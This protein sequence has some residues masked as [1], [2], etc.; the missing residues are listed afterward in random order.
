MS[1][2]NSCNTSV[3]IIN[4]RKYC[5][6]KD[7]I[8]IINTQ[9]TVVNNIITNPVSLDGFDSRIEFAGCTGDVFSQENHI[10]AL[11]GGT[12]DPKNLV[13]QTVGSN[14]TFGSFLR[15]DTLTVLKGDVRGSGANDLSVSRELC[16][17]VA[18]GDFSSILSGRNNTASGNLS[19]VVGGSNNISSGINSTIVS[20][21]ENINDGPGSVLIS[22]ISN[23][24]S[25]IGN[26]YNVIGC[27]I[28]NTA[29][30]EYN[31]IISGTNNI[32]Q[33]SE[34]SYNVISSGSRNLIQDS[35]F[36]WI[37]TGSTNNILSGIYNVIN[38]GSGNSNLGIE[39]NCINSGSNNKILNGFYNTIACGS[40]CLI[41]DNTKF[42]GIFTG[43]NNRIRLD[44]SYCCIMGGQNNDISGGIA[45]SI[46]SGLNNNIMI[47]NQGFNFIGSGI[48]NKVAGGFN[49]IVSGSNNLIDTS[50]SIYNAIVSGNNNK[51]IGGISNSFIGAG[52]NNRIENVN[53]SA[54]IAGASGYISGS[55]STIVG[56]SNNLISTPN[57]FAC[58]LGLRLT[59][60]NFPSTA[61]GQYNLE[62]VTGATGGSL[63]SE[64]IFMVGNGND[65]NNRANAFS[66]TVDGVCLAPLGFFTGGADF[67][68]YFESYSNY[69][70]KKI[71]CCKSAVMIDER[72]I[73]KSID[74]TTKEFIDS[75]NGFTV[76]D[77][78]KIM[79]ASDAPETIEPFGVIVF[80]SGFV[81][82]S[83]DEEW[84]GKYLKDSLNNFVYEDNIIE[85]EEEDCVYTTKEIVEILKERRQDKN[86]NIYYV[87]TPVKRTLQI[88]NPILEKFPLYNENGEWIEYFDKPK[89]VKKS[90]VI[91]N[92]KLSPNYDPSLVYIARSDRPEWNLVALLGQ[93]MI[94]DGQRVKPTWLKMN[95]INDSIHKYF[96]K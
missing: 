25:P 8:P 84:K 24:I 50:G 54:I 60:A 14:N 62:G 73:G 90:R 86:G 72:F 75:V 47:Q 31:S 65:D 89:L 21:S 51:I 93:V 45:N 55:N 7:K 35:S 95:K 91:R 52:S 44:A 43:I 49:S 2:S 78:G 94:E 59:S 16:S 9:K 20:G 38:N 3:Y 80:H 57:S 15:D 68:E 61:F 46:V 23:S 13:L 85:Y 58:G 56:G 17:Q 63:G 11:T 77:I 6:L 10:L 76:S 22:G 36:S 70:D 5:K 71:E 48:Q 39:F 92:R 37:G 30:G 96:I 83:Y 42:C 41:A 34:S 4:E 40:N 18:S 53:N 26:G 33:N 19:V 79:P 29:G 27:G 82:N 64:R 66:V 81:G 87:E 69:Q 28:G 32:V 12:V 67:A 74:P 88:K 1:Y